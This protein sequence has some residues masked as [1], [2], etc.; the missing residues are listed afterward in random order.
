MILPPFSKRRLICAASVAVRVSTRSLI[1]CCP[2]LPRPA[3][4]PPNLRFQTRMLSTCTVMEAAATPPTASPSLAWSAD[5]DAENAYLEEVLGDRAI[6][7]VDDMNA[8]AVGVLGNPQKSEDYAKVLA[9][10]DSK[11]KIPHLRKIHGM[12]YNFW[13][14]AANPRGVIRRLPSMEAYR[15]A[16]P[17]WEIVLDIDALGKEEGESWVYKGQNPLDLPSDIRP[18]GSYPKRT[19]LSLSRG[20]GDA[21]VVREFDLDTKQFISPDGGDQ[22]IYIPE[23]KSRVDWIDMNTLLIGTDFEKAGGVSDDDLP[24]SL[25]NSGYPI[26]VRVW[27]RG[28]PIHS[29]VEAYR[30]EVSDVSISGYVSYHR[31]TCLEWRSR[32]ITFYTA[33]YQLRRWQIVPPSTAGAIS[34]TE[35]SSARYRFLNTD[36]WFELNGLPEDCEVSS[37]GECLVITLRSDWKVSESLTYKSGSLLSVR[38]VDFLENGNNVGGP[39]TALYDILFEPTTVTSMEGFTATQNYLIVQSLEKVKSMLTFWKYESSSG[40][41]SC[42][43]CVG[44]EN[45]AQIRGISVRA[46]DSDKGDELWITQV[47]SIIAAMLHCILDQIFH[48]HISRSKGF[49]LAA[50]YPIPHRC[51]SWSGGNP[52]GSIGRSVEGPTQSV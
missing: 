51:S 24:P 33:R 3:T 22:G 17:A 40:S 25:T 43:T 4:R 16:Q 7:F 9:I 44:S 36:E 14:D 13:Q 10:L 11:D 45:E 27:A 19:L 1:S 6:R 31:G 8:K 49:L 5:E 29:A 2:P 23:A 20:G 38:I 35:K 41:A 21:T 46:V 42:W 34:E 26:S 50:Q 30:G 28:T 15:S 39:N 52:V 37:F 48:L 12:Y 18:P 32:A 47:S